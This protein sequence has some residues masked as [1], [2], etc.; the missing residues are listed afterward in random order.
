MKRTEGVQYDD[1]K[2]VLLPTEVA[3]MLR[4]DVKTVKAWLNDGT[5]KGF[6]TPGGHWRVSDPDLVQMYNDHATEGT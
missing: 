3:I 5:V 1:R 6:R 4:V 2:E